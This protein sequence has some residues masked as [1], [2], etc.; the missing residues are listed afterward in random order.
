MCG[1]CLIVNVI[2][3]WLDCLFISNLMV[4]NLKNV[5][6]IDSKDHKLK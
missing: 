4:I 2:S 1:I 6:Y 5:I 3:K